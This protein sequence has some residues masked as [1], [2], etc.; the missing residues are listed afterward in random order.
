MFRQLGCRSNVSEQIGAFEAKAACNF[1][2]GV[3]NMAMVLLIYI[4]FGVPEHTQ[5]NVKLALEYLSNVRA[6]GFNSFSLLLCWSAS[7]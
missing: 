7:L 3:I 5:W 4:Y 6:F 1:M 2:T